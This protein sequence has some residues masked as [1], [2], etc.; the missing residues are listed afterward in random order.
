[1]SK[2]IEERILTNI[3]ASPLASA[4]PNYFAA[5]L[6]KLGQDYLQTKNVAHLGHAIKLLRPFAGEICR[7]QG[8]AAFDEMIRTDPEVKKSIGVLYLAATSNTT[9]FIPPK[10]FTS[11]PEQENSI[12]AANFMEEVKEQMD[13]SFDDE[14]SKLVYDVLRYGNGIGELNYTTG[15]GRLKG[16]LTISGMRAADLKDTVIITDSFNRLI[17]YAPYGFPGIIAPLDT[18][19]TADGFV[20]LLFDSFE[21]QKDREEAI[22]STQMLPRHKCVH[23]RWLPTSSEARGENLLDAAFQPWW[24]KQQ[25]I[26]ILLHL[27]EEWAVPRKKGSLSEKPDIQRQF[28]AD[29]T[30]VTVNGEEQ[31][32]PPVVGLFNQM[33]TWGANGSIAVPYGYDIDIFQANSSMGDLLLKA[34]DFFNREISSAIT[35]QFLTSSQGAKSGGEKGVQ[36]H[37]DVLSLMILALKKIQSS[38]IR[39]QI[40][41]VL[42]RANFGKAAA[43]YAPAIDLGDSDG[44]PVSLDEIGFLAQSM[45]DFFT[46]SMLPEVGRKV[47]MPYIKGTN[48]IKMKKSA[49]KDVNAL[50]AILQSQLTCNSGSFSIDFED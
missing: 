2:Q 41:K 5:S 49:A 19:L 1:M 28:N 9:T 18:W 34:I 45:P 32:I 11:V 26:P 7:M 25:I 47:G 6:I 37:K 35:N 42:I 16:K 12:R 33:E 23:M 21:R 39:E 31:T 43:R 14:R 20:S 29:G 17:G 36:S 48:R 40:S 13:Y 24:A 38:A 46:D 8:L 3:P 50:Q 22:L 10:T 30:P 4:T 15:V 27:L 44:F